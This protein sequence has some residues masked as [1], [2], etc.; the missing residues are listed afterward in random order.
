MMKT[1]KPIIRFAAAG[2]CC[3]AFLWAGCASQSHTVK[4]R[5]KLSGAMEKASDNYEGEREVETTIERI[6]PVYEEDGSTPVSSLASGESSAAGPDSLKP[7]FG[8]VMSIMGGTGLL[9]GEDFYGY[10]HGLIGFGE[11][12][13]LKHR[14]LVYVEYMWAPV[15]Q[16]SRLDRSLKNGVLLL[17]IGGEV[18]ALMTPE[19]GFVGQTLIGG[20][21][22]HHMF[23]TYRNTI[24][25]DGDV[26]NSD[27]MSGFELYAGAGLNLIQTRNFQLGGEILPGVI[28]WSGNTYQGFDN[29]I[30]GPFWH[31]KFRINMSFID[32]EY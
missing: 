1:R 15:Q 12:L 10:N 11:N 6:E 25:S 23:W 29:D 30:F 26:I 17:A 27:H 9:S 2:I 31:L 16:T 8:R 18:R 21:A 7:R 4:R 13:S 28:L 32:H 14:A 24:Y 22:I 19:Y 20:L 3:V 5:G